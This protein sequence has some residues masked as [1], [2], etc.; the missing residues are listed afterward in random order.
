MVNLGS[1]GLLCARD[2]VATAALRSQVHL[3]Q[4]LQRSYSTGDVNREPMGGLG[5]AG[6][7]VRDSRVREIE[8][9]IAEEMDDEMQVRTWSGV[10]D[11]HGRMVEQVGTVSCLLLDCS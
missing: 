9:D 3:V 2:I 8:E 11:E 4:Q 5:A 1:R 6:K 10:Y 7:K